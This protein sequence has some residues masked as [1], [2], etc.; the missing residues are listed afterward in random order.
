MKLTRISHK[1]VLAT[2]LFISV[3]LVAIAAGTYGYFR[4]TTKELIFLQQYSTV[5]ILAK[6]LDQSI[7]T[8]QNAL[9]NATRIITTE[10]VNSPEAAQKWL[11]NRTSIKSIFAHGL[12]LFTPDGK[13]L[14]EFPDVGLRGMD[15]SYRDYCKQTV[16]TGKPQISTPFI[17]SGKN[18]PVIVM[19]APVFD[20]EGRLIVILVGA[21]DMFAEKTFLHDLTHQKIGKTGY[22]YLLAADRT[23]IMHPDPGLIMKQD[24]GPG[25]NPLFDKALEGFEGSG[26]TSN[27]K[28]IN[29]LA[30]FKR[31]QSTGWILAADYP[32][33]EAYQPIT[34]FRNYYMMGML[35]A[36]LLA[37][38]LSWRHGIGV[39]R[40][41]VSFAKQIDAMTSTDSDKRH[42]LDDS[43]GDELGQL[44]RS[45]NIM[46][47]ETQRRELELK[48][49]EEKFRTIAD[50]TYDWEFW[51]GMD[52]NLLY[53][54]PSCERVSGYTPEEFYQ[55]PD[56]IVSVI[57]PDDRDKYLQHLA[58]NANGTEP[59]CSKLNFRI[60]TRNNEELWIEHSC[61]EVLNN[62]G[63]HLGR[64]VSNRDITERKK[65]E[66][67]ILAFSSLME[68]KNAEL[69]AA[70]L[71]AEEATIAKSQFLATMSHE[72]RTPMNGVIGMT[73]LLLDTDLNEEQRQFADII[74]KS[75][76][77]LLGLIN[78]IL[79]FSKIEA[80]KMDLDLLD[81]D[82]RTTLED[83]VEMLAMRIV[84][85]TPELICRID[86]AV[87]PYLKGDPGR[88]RQIITNLAGNAIKFT[89]E[90]EIV[91]SVM[92]ESEENDSILLR[93]ELRDTGIG[94][95]ENRCAAIFSPFTQADGSTTRKYGGT[96]LGLAICRQLTELMGGE[97][98]V[99]SKEGVGSTFWFTS[100]FEKSAAFPET[101]EAAARI[102]ISG[103][104]VLVVDDN[105]TSRM[106]MITLLNIW[107]CR[108]ETAADGETA[109]SLLREAVSYGEPF[110]IAL[111]D[112]EMPGMDG[113]E[114]GRLIKG[115]P[116]LEPTLMIMVT[117]LAR[118]GDAGILEKIGFVGYLHKPVRQSLLYNCI[119]I[120][121]GRTAS[122]NTQHTGIIT[123]HTV[124]ESRKQGVL[125]LLAD[126]NIINQKVAQNMLSKLGYKADVAADGV[127][128]IRALEIINYDLVLMDCQ[129]PV[130]DGFEATVIIRD[131]GSKVKNHSVPIIAM[132]A[133]A[134]KGDREQCI[135]VGMD[136]YL[137]K[138]MKK[139][140]LAE[141]LD[142]W[143]NKGI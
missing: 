62:E 124:A 99:K 33:D 1:L 40:P 133:N 109:L 49:S 85:L 25:V 107:G 123:R 73:G 34:R 95:P 4:H 8:A 78:D 119:A 96:G 12:F 7:T 84:N 100:R 44:A 138:P 3:L 71:T 94:I 80:G 88:L 98:G 89:H 83:T 106:L 56:L 127:E 92:I 52:G 26:E 2:A 60:N 108:Y 141:I 35:F 50:H 69:G 111:L 75:G 19:T 137:A 102:D 128:V 72:I 37:I 45:F 77:A 87:P 136:D 110:R 31:L 131:P 51:R 59:G 6:N 117:S 142:K 13:L 18:R 103:T 43:R 23:M 114:L 15:L 105:D 5:S 112:L 122:G 82:L 143:L 104:K 125:I 81:F 28:G 90:G 65:A 36:L 54:S 132:T 67:K 97:I 70:L 139:V 120:A 118:R 140:E 130:M 74:H 126:D 57:H 10:T 64:R 9:I 47:G 93:F 38:T 76:E 46:L 22:L 41:L 135:T 32:I 113:L 121:L 16:A 101:A 14:V 42:K 115:D 86:P 79:D 68:K 58:D 20:P 11:D 30:S 27:S 29:V 24:S 39:S 116:Q 55:D 129:M 61:R 17:S 53:I 48:V 134:M 63:K 91:I 21:I 66:E